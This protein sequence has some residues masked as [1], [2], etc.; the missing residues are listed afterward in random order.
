[1]DVVNPFEASNTQTTPKGPSSSA[2][3]KETSRTASVGFKVVAMINQIVPNWS[4]T[5][6]RRMHPG[7][8]EPQNTCPEVNIASTAMET[9]LVAKRTMA[10]MLI[11]S[12]RLFA[13]II[14][15]LGP[16]ANETRHLD[17]VRKGCTFKYTQK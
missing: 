6:R 9:L 8:E 5:R 11:T 14:G 2:I 1:M 3:D 7:L 15:G 4:P 16:L 10:A 12:S 17:I 13:D